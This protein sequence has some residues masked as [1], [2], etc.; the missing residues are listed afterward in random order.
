M[1]N[2]D[3]NEEIPK[4]NY[5]EELKKFNDMI[6]KNAYS[7]NEI[8]KESEILEKKREEHDNAILLREANIFQMNNGTLSGRC[9]TQFISYIYNKYN[10]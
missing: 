9:A 5:L 7:A 10:N 2:N 4:F 6:N 8:A 3:W 1:Y